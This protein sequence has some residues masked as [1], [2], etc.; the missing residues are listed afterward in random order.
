M[1]AQIKPRINLEGRTPLQ[2]VIPLETPFIVFID[3]SSGC[4]FR[5]TFCPTGD[6]DLIK[7][8][9]RFQGVMN[10]DLY[11]KLID[12]LALF[13]QSIKVLRLYKDGE[14][15]L[16]K[17]LADMIGYA[18]SSGHVPYVDTTTNGALI[19]PSR[20]GPLI[21]AGLDK[22]NIS[23]YG[24]RPEQYAT[25]TK[26]EFDFNQFVA[27]VRWLYENKGNCEIVIKIPG[28]LVT[29]A[30]KQAF[31]E[32]FG[33]YCDRI[34]VENFAPCWPQF[35]VE[36]RLGVKITQGIYQQPITP[37]DTCPYIFYAMSINADGLA[38]SCFLDWGRKLI[39][40]DGRTQSLRDIW[41]SREFNELRLTHLEGKRRQNPVCAQ[42][43]QLSH[44]LP[45]NIDAYR[46]QL[47]PKV[48]KHMEE[49]R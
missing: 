38:S 10:F 6:R 16:N 43:G 33:D 32:A 34:F 13:P 27:N 17:R 5:C 46:D 45:D 20:M 39:V 14:P 12:D 41:N 44:C 49:V 9:G 37:T 47:I 19:D 30:E 35:D 21:E 28:E 3:P 4:N 22:V 8:T 1:K 7:G 25:F 2:N 18:K 36:Q 31:F 40:G 48:K 23:V 42:C 15:L 24:M 26:S 29:E 11:K